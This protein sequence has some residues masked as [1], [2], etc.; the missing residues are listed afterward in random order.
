MSTL[1]VSILDYYI[2]SKAYGS[3]YGHALCDQVQDHCGVSFS[4]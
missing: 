4:I 2:S 1:L 3:S